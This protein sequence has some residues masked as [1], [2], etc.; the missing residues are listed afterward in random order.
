ML[1]LALH[2]GTILLEAVSNFCFHSTI[3]LP[4]PLVLC[5]LLEN[6]ARCCIIVP[7]SYHHKLWEGGNKATWT[8]FL[9]FLDHCVFVGFFSSSITKLLHFIHS[10]LTPLQYSCIL[11]DSKEKPA[12]SID[13][14]YYLQ[15]VSTLINQTT[16]RN[17]PRLWCVVR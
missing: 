15:A 9:D 6:P 3:H 12:S 11:L 7:M 4:M 10:T 5:A 1:L 17:I 16:S 8:L 13:E 14:K 2:Y